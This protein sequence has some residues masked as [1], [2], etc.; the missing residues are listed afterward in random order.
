L[1]E[2][3]AQIGWSQV[4]EI[5]DCRRRAKPSLKKGE[6]LPGVPAIGLDRAL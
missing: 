5:A 2:K 6:K 4:G 3:S 1:G